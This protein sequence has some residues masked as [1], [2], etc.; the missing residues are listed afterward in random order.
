MQYFLGRYFF[1]IENRPEKLILVLAGREIP[2]FEYNWP[3]EDCETIVESVKK[4]GTWERKHVEKC[5]RVHGF[6]F[7]DEDL[8]FFWAMIQR[9]LTPSL[10][11]Q[12]MEQIL[13]RQ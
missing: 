11:I 3:P 9:G 10:V 6:I 8:E 7:G 4:L 2:D 13:R 5:L 12:S 1:D